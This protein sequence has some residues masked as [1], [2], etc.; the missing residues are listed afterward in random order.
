MWG[1]GVFLQGQAHPISQVAPILGPST[2]VANSNTILQS[3]QDTGKQT[4]LANFFVSRMLMRDL[5]AIGNL[6]SGKNSRVQ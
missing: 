4:F 1:G 6:L 2:R 3:D 5:F